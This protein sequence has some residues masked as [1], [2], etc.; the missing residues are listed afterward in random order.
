MKTVIAYEHC[1]AR[2]DSP[3]GERFSI[4]CTTPGFVSHS[5]ERHERLPRPMPR[6][7]ARARHFLAQPCASRGT[8][9]DAQ[10]TRG[11]SDRQPNVARSR[12]CIPLRKTA[13]GANSR[14]A[15]KLGCRQSLA[16]GLEK[17][18]AEAHAA[19]RDMI[20]ATKLT[21]LDEE[22]WHH[23]AAPIAQRLVSSG[24]CETAGAEKRRHVT[25]RFAAR[26]AGLGKNQSIPPGN[27]HEFKEH[28]NVR[29][30]G[31]PVH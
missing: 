30:N 2:W 23:E 3:D 7:N 28:F 24:S 8:S 27:H 25:R 16:S 19:G 22:P 21:F 1:F 14:L 11:L 6:G 4:E 10:G 13:R 17:A 5:D 26:F 12:T 9:F 29:S 31:R 20:D 15:R 18:F